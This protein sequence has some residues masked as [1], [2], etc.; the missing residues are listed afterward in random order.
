MSHTDT[1]DGRMPLLR[2]GRSGLHVSPLALGTMMFGDRTDRDE[3]ARIVDDARARGV[4]FIDTANAYAAGRSEEITGALIAADRDAWIVATKCGMPAGE[5][6][7]ERGLSRRNLQRATEASLRRLG[8]DVIDIQYLHKEDHGTPLAETVRAMGDLIRAGY[9]RYFGVSNHRAWRLARICQLCDEEGI[10]RPVVAQVYYHALYRAAEL[11]LLPACAA[12]G[13]GVV[14]YSP[15]ARGVLT[16]KYTPHGEPPQDSRAAAGNP[17]MLATEYH[18]ENLAAA[19]SLRRHVETRGLQ[20]PAFAGAW[21]LANPM[22]QGIVAGPRTLAQWQAYFESLNTTVT[23]EDE[24]AVDAVA[25]SG[26]SAIARYVDPAYPPEGRP[27]PRP[28]E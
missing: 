27:V 24:A 3:A 7:N 15:L 13:I 26:T 14:A 11:E 5:G 23:P 20:L 1:D 25:P 22:V 9:V 16:G 10:D 28:G 2:L 6:P 18:P 8:T 12:L 4:N 21:V 19:A 17:R